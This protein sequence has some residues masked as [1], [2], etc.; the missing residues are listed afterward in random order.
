M[1]KETRL[2]GKD[3]DRQVDIYK[4]KFIWQLKEVSKEDPGG[5]VPVCRRNI[6]SCSCESFPRT[7]LR[8]NRQLS[9]DVRVPSRFFFSYQIVLYYLFKN[10]HGYTMEPSGGKA[11]ARKRESACSV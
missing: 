9:M 10:V 4:L 8:T 7:K 2:V 6:S 1:R 3:K 11:S 5:G